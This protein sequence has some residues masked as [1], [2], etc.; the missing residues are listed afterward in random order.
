L[1]GSLKRKKTTLWKPP[2]I[3]MHM[4]LLRFQTTSLYERGITFATTYGK[5][6][7]C[8]MMGVG[9]RL[10]TRK[11]VEILFGTHWEYNRNKK[12]GGCHLPMWPG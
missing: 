8:Y 11:Y 3:W 2:K 1:I 10:G 6:M 7:N 9:N 12:R 5:K 4:K